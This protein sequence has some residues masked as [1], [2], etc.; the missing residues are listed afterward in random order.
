MADYSYTNEI[1]DAKKRVREMQSRAREKTAEERS[2]DMLT[3]MMRLPSNKDRALVLALLYLL[4]NET[5]DS[6]L[7]LSILTILL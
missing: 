1:N 7:L 6:E 2:T 3:L 5:A 4:S